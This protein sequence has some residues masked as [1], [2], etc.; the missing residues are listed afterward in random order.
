MK[1]PRD[2]LGSAIAPRKKAVSCGGSGSRSGEPVGVLDDADDA[3]GVGVD[4]VEV[5]VMIQYRRWCALAVEK[6]LGCTRGPIALAPEWCDEIRAWRRWRGAD[7][8]RELCLSS[9]THVNE[10]PS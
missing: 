7:A 4:G 1:K 2:S 5:D 10:P 6:Q 8:A 3:L 9:P